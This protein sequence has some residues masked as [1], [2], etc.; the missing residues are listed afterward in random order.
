MRTGQWISIV[1]VGLSLA[2]AV[3]LHLISKDYEYVPERRSVMSTDPIPKEELEID[4]R[5]ASSVRFSGAIE[6]GNVEVQ[7]IFLNPINETK[8]DY[9][10]FQISFNTHSVNLANYDITKEVVIED[11]KG[12]VVAEG[13]KWEEIHNRGYHHVLGVLTV[14]DLKDEKSLMAKDVEW[15]KLIIKGIPKIKTREFKWEKSDRT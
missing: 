5:I 1:A 6:P 11:S 14:S 8:E 15:I 12:R 2:T 4:E 7:A 3:G 10:A 9:L 13:F